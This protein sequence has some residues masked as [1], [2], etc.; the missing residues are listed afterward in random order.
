[1]TDRYNAVTVVLDR[2]YRTDDAEAILTALRQIRGVLSVEPNVADISDHVADQ[3]VRHELGQ[4]LLD[5][6]H[7]KRTKG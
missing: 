2:D 1:M 6:L 3:R 5:V 4:K 7:P